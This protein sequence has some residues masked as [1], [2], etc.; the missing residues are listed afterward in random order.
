MQRLYL[1]VR[2]F[3]LKV[4]PFLARGCALGARVR[5][6]W[7]VFVALLDRKHL[8]F[9][10]DLFVAALCLP[11]AIWLRVGTLEPF[12]HTLLLKHALVYTLVCAAVYLWL[13][14]YRS[15]WHYFSWVQVAT[16]ALAGAYACVLYFPLMVLM[17][18]KDTWPRSVIFVLWALSVGALCLSRVTHKL[19]RARWREDADH[20][21][22]SVPETRLLLLGSSAHLQKTFKY[23]S[24]L[25]TRPYEVLGAL[26]TPAHPLTALTG[27]KMLGSTKEVEEII[28]Q[29]NLE[30]R[31]PHHLILLEPIEETPEFLLNLS[32][33]LHPLGVCL[34]H[35][36]TD[37]GDNPSVKPFVLEEL[38]RLVTPHAKKPSSFLKGKRVLVCQAGQPMGR[39]IA[40]LAARTPALKN[41][42]VCDL[43]ETLLWDTQQLLKEEGLSYE[44]HLLTS[45]DEDSLRSVLRTAKPDVVIAEPSLSHAS[46]VEAHLCQSFMLLMKEVRTLAKVCQEENVP[47]VVFLMPG[48]ASPPHSFLEVLYTLVEAFLISQKV[49]VVRTGSIFDFP[50]SLP[51]RIKR[52]L[53]QGGFVE[54]RED[55]EIYQSLSLDMLGERLLGVLAQLA[56]K[57]LEEGQSVLLAPDLSVTP[58][59][60]VAQIVA[61][62]PLLG[63]P[64]HLR[65][66]Q[67]GPVFRGISFG[68]QVLPTPKGSVFSR[69][70]LAP[71]GLALLGK[72]LNRLEAVAKKGQEDDLRALLRG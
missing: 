31:H 9:V 38:L 1:K 2:P 35:L 59:E 57:P 63:E 66:V 39:V 27:V 3:L 17:G 34:S 30:G 64:P 22:T 50:D 69:I 15:V 32:K 72:T 53:T 54:V 58:K 51:S 49:I 8:V 60:L 20:H 61:L 45:R 55:L 26:A 36:D 71:E 18:E 37:H 4:R 28:H 11:L 23:L 52:A 19:L 41:L 68:A 42:T 46:F 24:G 47:S 40:Q 48:D 25:S 70:A 13:Q 56:R 7:D 10:H 14:L 65:V 5:E 29:L 12:S 33:V 6:L 62:S 44:G 16:V 43:S 21:Y 67:A